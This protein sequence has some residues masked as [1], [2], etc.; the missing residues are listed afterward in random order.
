ME[1]SPETGSH[2]PYYYYQQKGSESQTLAHGLIKQPG[3]EWQ[4]Y[5]GKEHAQGNDIV[6]GVA[7]HAAEIEG[8][9]GEDACYRH[10][11][12]SS[13]HAG[14]TTSTAIEVVE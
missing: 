7:P 8:D 2:S 9:I 4:K 13:A 5:M 14:S 3:E 10:E 1:V 11:G 12:E 6:R